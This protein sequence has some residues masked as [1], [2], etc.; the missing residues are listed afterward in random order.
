MDSAWVEALWL[1]LDEHWTVERELLAAILEVSHQT[2]L[3]LLAAHSKRGT[4][5]PEPVR[6]PRPEQPKVPLPTISPLEFAM[7]SG[8][9]AERKGV[10]RGR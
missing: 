4:K 9:G 10:T 8:L 5:L 6:V 3:V 7:L 1:S 2:M